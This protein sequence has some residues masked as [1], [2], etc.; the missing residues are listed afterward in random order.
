MPSQFSKNLFRSD[1]L[2]PHP[3][4][5]AVRAPNIPHAPASAHPRHRRPDSRRSAECLPSFPRTF[6]DLIHFHRI[7]KLPPCV[8]PTSHMHQLRPTHAIVGLIAVGLQNAFPVFQ[9]PFRTFTSSTH[10]EVE[11]RLAARLTVLPQIRFV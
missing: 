5:S 9:E 7:H 3:Q 4:T 10:T 6:S 1:S 8:R 2:S 11:Y